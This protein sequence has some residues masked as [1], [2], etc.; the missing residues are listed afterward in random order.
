MIVITDIPVHVPHGEEVNEFV[1][2]DPRSGFCRL[3]PVLSLFDEREHPRAHATLLAHFPQRSRFGSFTLVDQSFRELPPRRLAYRYEYHLE[4][5]VRLSH[6]CAARRDLSF[7]PD[8]LPRCSHQVATAHVDRKPSG[9][10]AVI[11]RQMWIWVAMGG[12]AGSVL[13]YALGGVIQK[14]AA[15]AFP[16]G[17]LAVNVIG[18]FVIGVLTQHFL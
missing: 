5:V 15:A 17:T 11:F 13:R 9:P 16:V 14:S 2:S 6:D 18:C 4:S 8:G 3:I 12:A 10:F 1:V 7:G